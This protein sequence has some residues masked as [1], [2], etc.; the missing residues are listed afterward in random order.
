V[1]VDLVSLALIS[2]PLALSTETEKLV[3]FNLIA[4]PKFWMKTKGN[5]EP[6][7]LKNKVQWHCSPVETYSFVQIHLFPFNPPLRLYQN[8]LSKHISLKGSSC[9]ISSPS[10]YALIH[11]DLWGLRMTFY[12]LSTKINNKVQ[13]FLRT[14]SKAYKHMY[15]INQFKFRE[16]ETL[17]SLHSS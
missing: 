8:H 3:A 5:E 7:E 14:W 16:S 4:L 1:V 15:A 11:K 6:S 10:T 9:G 2:L 13:W 17:S 12:N